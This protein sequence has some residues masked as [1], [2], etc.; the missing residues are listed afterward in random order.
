M[1]YLEPFCRRQLLNYYVKFLLMSFETDIST[2]ST[3]KRVA[4]KEI[5]IKEMLLLQC[6]PFSIIM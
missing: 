6:L 4:F 5:E 2:I 1:L 3:V